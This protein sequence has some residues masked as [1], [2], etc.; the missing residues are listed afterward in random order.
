MTKE[1]EDRHR[2]NTLRQ[3]AKETIQKNRL[4]AFVLNKQAGA[5]MK[6]ERDRISNLI[7]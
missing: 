7:K 5:S 6:K 3:S 2:F 1:A 4:D